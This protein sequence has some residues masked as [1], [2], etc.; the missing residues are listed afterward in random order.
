MRPKGIILILLV[1][2]VTVL[3]PGC[4]GNTRAGEVIATI[5]TTAGAETPV[6]IPSGQPGSTA[7]QPATT[8]GHTPACTTNTSSIVPVVKLPTVAPLNQAFLDSLLR[9]ITDA[10]VIATVGHPL[11]V[12]PFSQDFGYARGLQIPGSGDLGLPA[13]GG[14]ESSNT[15]SGAVAELPRKFDLRSVSKVTPV[16]DQNPYG[17]CWSFAT[18]GSMESCLLPGETW[19]FSEDNLVL[20]SGFD[21]GTDAYNWGGSLQMGTAYLVRWGGPVEADADAY[22]DALTPSDLSPLK[23]VQEVDWIPARGGPLDNDNIKRAVMQYGGAYVA[24]CWQGSASG[25][26]NYDASTS[27]YY[28]IGALPANHAVLIA[29]WDDDYPASNFALPPFGNGAFLVKNSWGTGF[30]DAG[31]LWVSYYDSVFGRTD[32]MGI[33]DDSEPVDNYAGVYQYDPLGDVNS[34]G[35]QSETAW[36]ANVFTAEEPA[37]LAAVGFYTLAPGSSYEVYTGTELATL[38]KSA[39]GTI[40]YMGYHTVEVPGGMGLDG[41]RPFIVAVK[42]T[43][44]G[45]SEPVAIEYPIEDFTSKATAEPGQSFVSPD[46]KDWSDLTTVDDPNANV[47]L[48]AYVAAGPD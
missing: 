12:R 14:D 42:L 1:L 40:P 38:Q 21:H 11:G 3:L 29:G 41:G 6:V 25:S 18:L 37:S 15:T 46:G 22:G 33:V 8:S 24:F 35:Y 23:H 47:C 13:L 5:S 26:L 28:Y 20:T 10:S 48:K 45:T 19:D 17:T 30:G 31:Y 43:S 34:M 36:F 39:S 7:A 32:L 44:P 9:P 27:S 16:G 4:G 2:A